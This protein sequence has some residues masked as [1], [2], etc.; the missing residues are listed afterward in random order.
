[1][2]MQVP[3]N[4]REKYVRRLSHF[5]WNID[6]FNV[7]GDDGQIRVQGAADVKKHQKALADTKDSITTVRC[8]SSYGRSGPVFLLM[9]GQ[10]K[11]TGFTDEALVQLGLPEG[12]AVIMTPCG[13]MTDDVRVL[14]SSTHI[15]L[16]FCANCMFIFI[17]VDGTCA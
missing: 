2:I 9:Q 7:R 15:N 12:S 6:E 14:T 11:K 8:G 10:R 17:G 13:Y 5:I 1:M 4:E 16:R 3:E